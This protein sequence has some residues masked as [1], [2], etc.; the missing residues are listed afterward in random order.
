[1]QTGRG[2]KEE[3]GVGLLDHEEGRVR[4]AD[5]AH[6]LRRADEAEQRK[7]AAKHEEAHDKLGRERARTAAGA[8]AAAA[9]TADGVQ[10]G[11]GNRV[12]AVHEHTGHRAA[13]QSLTQNTTTEEKKKTSRKERETNALDWR[14]VEDEEESEEEKT[15]GGNQRTRETASQLAEPRVGLL[16]LLE[17][18]LRGVLLDVCLQHTDVSTH[19]HNTQQQKGRAGENKR[20]V[21]QICSGV[22]PWIMDATVRQRTSTSGLMSR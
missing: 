16:D 12:Q 13:A 20:K 17:L 9:G 1:M 10:D 15:E 3:E 18:L 7:D 6:P 8:A 2:D 22:L 19:K 11:C 14:V 21:S 4:D 5:E